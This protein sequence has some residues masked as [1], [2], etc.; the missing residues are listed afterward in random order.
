MSERP[1]SPSPSRPRSRSS[2]RSPDVLSKIDT[3]IDNLLKINGL[4]ENGDDDKRTFEI[5]FYRWINNDPIMKDK[6][7]AINERI[8]YVLDK[9]KRQSS[10]KPITGS[11][12][13]HE[14]MDAP[15]VK[16]AKGGKRTGRRT[17]KRPTARRR[18]R[19]GSSKARTTR[20]K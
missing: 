16:R 14:I 5:W 7:N 1:P 2:S 18:V 12:L 10:L 19:R 20:R 3:N 6:L 13:I 8:L 17:Q 9:K 4:F 11:V 15:V